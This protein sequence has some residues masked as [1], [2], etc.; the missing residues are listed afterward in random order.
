MGLK[1][2][3]VMHAYVIQKI[4]HDI[5]IPLIPCCF[6]FALITLQEVKVILI[7]LTGTL[8]CLIHLFCPK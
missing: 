3:Y 7:H 5:T 4:N 2:S 8:L 6:P 1:L